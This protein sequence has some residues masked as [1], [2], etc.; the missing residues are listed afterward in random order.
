MA[1]TWYRTSTLQL[2]RCLASQSGP[3]GISDAVP[4]FN[5]DRLWWRSWS[6]PHGDNAHLLIMT[7]VRLW[8]RQSRHLVTTTT[9]MIMSSWDIITTTLVWMIFFQR[10][11]VF[12]ISR[13]EYQPPISSASNMST[14]RVQ[15]EQGPV[16]AES[17]ITFQHQSPRHRPISAC[18]PLS[19]SPRPY[20]PAEMTPCHS[21]YI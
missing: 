9:K 10:F 18:S 8:V 11:I 6:P 14:S 16:W 21:I 7:L 13:I 17:N 1:K 4:T 15:Y 19:P 12:N 20:N 3:K 5:G 2:E